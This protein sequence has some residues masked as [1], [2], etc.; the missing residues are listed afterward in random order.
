MLD[1]RRT[2]STATWAFLALV[3]LLMLLRIVHLAGPLDDP[4]SWRQCDTV[5]GSREFA[6]HGIDL[7][8]PSVGWLGAHRHMIYEFPL[9]Q[10]LAAL[11]HRA[12]GFD[13]IWDRVVALCFFTLSL[14]WLHRL[15]RVIAD[16]TTARF[17][18]FAY[19]LLP[20]GQFYSRAATVDFAAQAFATGFLYHGLLA[21]RGRSITHAAVAAICGVLT[22]WLKVPFLVPVLI[23]FLLTTC[24]SRRRA[25]WIRAGLIV[26]AVSLGFAWWRLQMNAL[27][28]AAPDW[29]WL[30]GFYKEID[31]W[32]FYA[33]QFPHLIERHDLV[34]LGRR[35]V[36]D[37]FTAPGIVLVLFAY[38]WQHPGDAA[39]S[40]WL[41]SVRRVSPGPLMQAWVWL[42]GFGLFSLLYLPIEIGL[43]YTQIP[44]LA[45][46]ALLI[47]LGGSSVLRWA[48]ERSMLP[49]VG[50]AM[51][52]FP[53][54]AIATPLRLQWYRVDTLRVE[55]GV[56]IQR[57]VPPDELV[58]VVDH[59]S[60]YSDPRVLNRAD[61]MGFA[62]KA[63]HLTPALLEK[64]EGVGARW[65]A[66][67]SE[68]GVARLAP[69]EY[70]DSLQVGQ[71]RLMEHG[72][73]LGTL[74]LYSLR[75]SSAVPD[76]TPS[77]EGD[78]TKQ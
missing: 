71:E 41:S 34:R 24:L 9:P 55:A 14:L 77:A 18:T 60:D 64:L 22:S 15:V 30:P 48:R 28:S 46:A 67:I 11:L 70:L 6:R 69:P 20:L 61:R 40:A 32:W 58:V 12:F 33:R 43:E 56:A 31:P 13:P 5:T 45:P 59:S 27:N 68:P 44:V 49:A 54:I 21:L 1:S 29:N 50:A 39:R 36:T 17:T 62:V 19:L 72:V 42:A 38:G 23:P 3:L 47:A 63:E 4:N 78:L 16:E 74:H 35:M 66:W 10:S 25:A 75:R 2:A 26:L 73:E 53:L 7:L 57:R 51:L 37:V 52:A 76:S 65:V 8:H